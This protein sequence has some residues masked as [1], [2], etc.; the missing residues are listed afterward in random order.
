MSVLPWRPPNL[1]RCPCGAVL[2]NERSLKRH[3]EGKTMCQRRGE[4]MVQYVPIISRKLTLSNP[5]EHGWE[6][7]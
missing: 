2:T 1:W 4:G 3:V 6:S 7:V 5:P